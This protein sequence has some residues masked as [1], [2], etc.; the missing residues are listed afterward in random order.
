MFPTTCTVLLLLTLVEPVVV[1]TCKILHN[2]RPRVQCGGGKYKYVVIIVTDGRQ[3]CCHNTPFKAHCV[4]LTNDMCTIMLA[5]YET[6]Y[7]KL[8]IIFICF[9]VHISIVIVNVREL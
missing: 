1:E 9:I 2:I 7:H 6:L 8:I 3:T 5:Y 4:N